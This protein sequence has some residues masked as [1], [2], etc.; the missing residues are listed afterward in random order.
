MSICEEGTNPIVCLALNS[1]M[2]KLAQEPFM[3]DS[4]KCAAKIKHSHVCLNLLVEGR[5]KVIHRD[6]QLGLAGMA[7]PESYMLK[8]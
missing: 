5:E 6:E 7:L 3:G 4:V 8:S 2:G 1:I